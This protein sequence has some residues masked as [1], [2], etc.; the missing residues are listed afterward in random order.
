MGHQLAE[1]PIVDPAAFQ[2]IYHFITQTQLMQFGIWVILCFRQAQQVVR[3]HAV[4]LRQSGDTVRADFLVVVSL[5]ASKGRRGKSCLLRKLLQRKGVRITQILQS[6]PVCQFD[7]HTSHL[8]FLYY[9]TPFP[10]AW[11][12]SLLGA[13]SYFSD[14][15]ERP[16]FFVTVVMHNA[17]HLENSMTVRREYALRESIVIHVPEQLLLVRWEVFR[18]DFFHQSISFH[19]LYSERSYSWDF[20][21]GDSYVD[22][23]VPSGF[24]RS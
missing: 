15:R 23:S 19:T 7:I 12:N 8:L 20:F 6:L 3:G 18:R 21:S 24:C 10:R 14:I 11:K 22:F 4:E 1:Q 16:R 2:N 13:I 5:I 9:S 17:M